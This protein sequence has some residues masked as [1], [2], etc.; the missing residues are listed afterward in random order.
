VRSVLSRPAAVLAALVLLLMSFSTALAQSDNPAFIATWTRTDQ[1]VADGAVDRTWIW[2]PLTTAWGE[3]E[4]YVEG[5]NG[6]RDVLYFDKARMEITHP[7]GNPDDLWY[8]TNGLLVMEMITGDMQMGDNS[9]EPHGA[10]EVNVAGDPDDPNG[11]TY[12]TFTDLLDASA[13]EAVDAITRTVDRAGNVD[14]DAGYADYEI[15]ATHYVP[16]TDHWVADPFWEFMTS[17]SLVWEDGALATDKLFEDPVYGTGYPVTEAYWAEVEVGGV[18]QDVLMQCF[19]RR[20]LTYTPGNDA[21]WQVEAGNVGRHYYTWRYGHEMPGAETA[22]SYM[23]AV[24]DE[25]A[26][27]IPV[28]CG[29]SLVEVT[30][31]IWGTDSLEERIA[32]TLT[33]L[34]SYNDVDFGES[35]L[36]NALYQNDATVESVTLDG[37]TATVNLSGTI[38]SAGVCDDPRIVG[39]LEETVKAFDGVEAAVILL[40]GNPLFPAP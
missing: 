35:G 23:V 2:G 16:E 37:S 12:A 30:V 31:P 38:P 21:G 24:G 18:A 6:E 26:N 28:G 4:D 9:F 10:A 40:N 15:G 3:T 20:C 7:D 19:Q 27:G 29:D 32:A 36:R 33:V 11:P 14:V 22:T 34:L 25:G 17:S 1:P 8:V 13:G 5:V 39:Q